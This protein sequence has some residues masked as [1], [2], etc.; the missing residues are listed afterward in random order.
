M[1]C[2]SYLEVGAG[3]FEM[4]RFNSPFATP[5]PR[6][7]NFFWMPIFRVPIGKSTAVPNSPFLAV[8]GVLANNHGRAVYQ[9]LIRS[10]ST[11]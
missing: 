5:L 10:F 8:V 2:W 9:G 1:I 4:K 7:W 3:K 6:R 11:D